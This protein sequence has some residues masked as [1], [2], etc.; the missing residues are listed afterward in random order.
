M[1]ATPIILA[2]LMAHAAHATTGQMY[3]DK[4]YIHHLT[5]VVGILTEFGF[6]EELATQVGYLH[7]ILEDTRVTPEVLRQTGFSAD[8]VR[9]VEFCTDE[10]GE[11]R[12]TRKA[13]TYA[14]VRQDVLAYPNEPWL[15]AGLAAKWA[16]RI[17]N[18][19]A[20]T[21]DNPGLLKMYRKEWEAF[22]NAYM[23][24]EFAFGDDVDTTKK[25]NHIVVEYDRLI[26]GPA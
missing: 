11:N 10:P 22:R 8:V 6:T 17:S 20:A 24:P 9:G 5:D 1:H 3:G 15:L 12:K 18:L 16:D 26:G 23:P 14:R 25:W 7:D 4:P 21:R 2:R 19:R 13:L